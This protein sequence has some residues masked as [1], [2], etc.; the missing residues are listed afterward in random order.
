MKK[1]IVFFVIVAIFLMIGIVSMMIMS[2]ND[3]K[4]KYNGVNS[5]LARLLLQGTKTK[6]ASQLNDEFEKECIDIS[7][8]AKQ[9]YIKASLI[10]LNEDLNKA[11]EL[12]EDLILNSTFDDFEKEYIGLKYQAFDVKRL[13]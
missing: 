12:L 11:L 4:E 3:K 10:F 13:N 9:D 8:K 6:S 1:G 5:L 2:S 7:F